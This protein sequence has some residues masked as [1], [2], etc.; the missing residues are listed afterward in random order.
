MKYPEIAKRFE[1]ILEKRGIKGYDLAERAGL[2]SAAVSQYLNG[3]RC[4][5]RNTAQ[6]LSEVLRVNP[7]WLMG[8][9]VPMESP[10]TPPAFTDDQKR[11]IDAMLKLNPKNLKRLQDFAEILKENQQTQEAEQGSSGQVPG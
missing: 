1:I 6:S 10:I 9:D 5:T 4:P 11:V 8:F 2:S 7:L 3:V